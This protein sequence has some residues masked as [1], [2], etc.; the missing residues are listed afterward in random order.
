MPVFSQYSSRALSH[1]DNGGRLSTTNPFLFA[2]YTNGPTTNPNLDEI[3]SRFDQIEEAL[4]IHDVTG[5]NAGRFAQT[6]F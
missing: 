3:S 5:A 6:F 4:A 1:L 2:R